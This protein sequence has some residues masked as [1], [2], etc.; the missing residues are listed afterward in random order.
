MTIFA[1]D[2]TIRSRT[3]RQHPGTVRVDF[4][5]EFGHNVDVTPHKYYTP[6]PCSTVG[7]ENNIQSVREEVFQDGV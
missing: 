1:Y 7:R 3:I 6:M 4:F 5:R 2:K